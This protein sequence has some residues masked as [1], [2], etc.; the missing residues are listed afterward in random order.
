MT[1]QKIW[2]DIS[3]NRSSAGQG[4]TVGAAKFLFWGKNWCYSWL[5]NI[6]FNG[7]ED[8]PLLCKETKISARAEFLGLAPS[9]SMHHLT[10]Q[11]QGMS[12]HWSGA[13]LWGTV[14]LFAV[15]KL[16]G[17]ISWQL[18]SLIFFHRER[19]CVGTLNW[20]LL[21]SAVRARF[22]F[23]WWIFGV[24]F[25]VPWGRCGL[26]SGVLSFLMFCRVFR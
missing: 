17:F 10:Q 12:G 7:W 13:G 16:W 26:C 4:C 25:T 11:Q 2:V 9:G 23:H 19:I 8:Q 20:Q 24:D 21:V 15:L 3:C 1:Q 22:A 18:L 5:R 14:N 6:S